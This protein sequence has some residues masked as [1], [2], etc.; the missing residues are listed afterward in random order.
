MESI[1]TVFI[2][3]CLKYIELLSAVDIFSFYDYGIG[4]Y[5][6]TSLQI[7]GRAI[8]VE[9]RLLKR[10]IWIYGLNTLRCDTSNLAET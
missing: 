9:L 3:W 8:F 6:S 4:I 7:R 10:I 5:N 2:V 1:P